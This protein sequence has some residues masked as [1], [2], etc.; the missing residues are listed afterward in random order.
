MTSAGGTAMTSAG[1]TAMNGTAGVTMT[2]AGGRSLGQGGASGGA[3]PSSFGGRANGGSSATGSAGQGTGTGTF[4]IGISADKNYLV[5]AD[6]TPF[7]IRGDSAWSILAELSNA[8]STLYLDSRQAHGFNA[9]V[10]TLI[11]PAFSSHDPKWRNADGQL[12]FSNPDDFTTINDA[13]F[14]HVDWFLTEAEKRGILVI[15]APAYIGYGCGAE[16]WCTRMKTNGVAKLAQYGQY[17]GNRYKSFKNILWLNGGDYTPGTTGSPSELD[18]VNAVA[19]AIRTAEGGVHLHAAHWSTEVSGGEG[20]SV[21]WLDVDTTY[22][23]TSPHL[24]QKTLSD[25]TRDAGKRPFFLLESM[26]ENEH[27][28]TM[29]QLRAQMYQPMLSGGTGFMFG[30]FPIW[31]MWSPGDAAWQ[32]DNGKYPGGWRTALNGAGTVAASLAFQFFASIPWQTMAPDQNHQLL[33]GGYGS[34]DAFALCSADKAGTIA[35]TYAT[36]GLNLQVDLSRFKGPISAR[37]FDPAAGTYTD[38][39]TNPLTNS[40]MKTFTQAAPNADGSADWILLLQ[41]K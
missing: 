4:P 41:V 29:T 34:G 27:S 39:A 7:S 12:P 13:Y 25:R 36:S 23:Y 6:G 19:N 18:L 21:P 24:Y 8:D 16:G 31:G 14:T 37:W 22:S 26:Y 2:G 10:S 9:V 17:V 3:N 35:V 15:L 32:F 30:N 28:A 1:G 11:E 40:G 20:P 33:V 38:A 5:A